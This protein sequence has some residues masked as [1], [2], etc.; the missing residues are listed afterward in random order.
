MTAE[1]LQASTNPN[2]LMMTPLV[3]EIVAEKT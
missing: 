2:C 3:M 1:I